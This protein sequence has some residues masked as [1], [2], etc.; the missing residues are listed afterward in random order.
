MMEATDQIGCK[1]RILG[2]PANLVTVPDSKTDRSLS[3][4]LGNVRPG[5]RSAVA[6]DREGSAHRRT[7]VGGDHTI[8][9]MAKSKGARI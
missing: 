5:K 1:G 2:S 3:V 6:V 9:L 4:S 8:H 7:G